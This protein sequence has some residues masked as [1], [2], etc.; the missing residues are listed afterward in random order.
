MTLRSTARCH[1]GLGPTR[2][3]LNGKNK[4][5]AMCGFPG[6]GPYFGMSGFG[7]LVLGSTLGRDADDSSSHIGAYGVYAVPPGQDG[8]FLLT[9][10]HGF[11]AAE[12][13]VYRVVG[14]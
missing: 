8:D 9:G 12:V 2:M 13:E 6:N 11:R 1:A 3:G 5:V 7:E 14:R 10:V 4:S